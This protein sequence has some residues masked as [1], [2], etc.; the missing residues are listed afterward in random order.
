MSRRYRYI[1]VVGSRTATLADVENAIKSCKLMPEHHIIV[2]GGARGAD[3]HAK[4]I[5]F[6]DGFHYIEVPAHWDGPLKKGAGFARNSAI[7]DLADRIIAVWDG[8]SKGTLDTMNKAKEAG[9]DP[10]VFLALNGAAGGDYEAG[11]AASAR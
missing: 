11:K 4:T 9:K 3:A 8:K 5:A 2:S 7:V 10:V 6:R 1:A